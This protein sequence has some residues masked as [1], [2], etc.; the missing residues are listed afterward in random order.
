MPDK[1][2]SNSGNVKR[3][4]IM[5]NKK[6]LR[7][8]Y[9]SCVIAFAVLKLTNKKNGPI[10]LKLATNL[11]KV[12]SRQQAYERASNSSSDRLIL[13]SPTNTDGNH[14]Y[15]SAAVSYNN[16]CLLSWHLGGRL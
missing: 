16:T 11:L 3:N 15:G 1:S 6:P 8:A 4:A 7:V 2:R 12:N 9:Y 10:Q 14:K 5:L 13:W